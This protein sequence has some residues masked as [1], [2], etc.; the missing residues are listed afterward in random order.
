MVVI[1]ED[2][3]DDVVPVDET[4]LSDDPTVVVVVAAAA[5]WLLVPPLSVEVNF[6]DS[7]FCFELYAMPSVLLRRNVKTNAKCVGS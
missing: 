1:K 3:E 5:A 7:L 2:D 4:V 6:D